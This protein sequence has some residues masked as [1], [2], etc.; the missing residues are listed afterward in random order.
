MSS[1]E[2]V[3]SLGRVNLLDESILKNNGEYVAEI[4]LQPDL[5]NTTVIS[6]KSDSL[7]FSQF[8]GSL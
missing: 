1:Q 8:T 6:P 4:S 7:W 5:Q 3:V 2:I